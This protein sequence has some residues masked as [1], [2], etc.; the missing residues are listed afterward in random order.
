MKKNN[1]YF[2]A[3]L[4]RGAYLSQER[5]RAKEL[6][7]EDPVNESYNATTKV[8]NQA[9]EYF[10]NQIKVIG[11]DTE[12]LRV[13]IATHNEETVSFTIERFLIE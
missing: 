11:V 7:Y 13:M 12:K 5:L 8:Y 2:G 6:G 1:F 10:L 4:V 9:I 3:K